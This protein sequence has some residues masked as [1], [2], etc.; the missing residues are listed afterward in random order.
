[1]AVITTRGA[2]WVNSRFAELV[3]GHT[4]RDPLVRKAL[5][6]GVNDLVAG[7]L[8][9]HTKVKTLRALL[10]SLVRFVHQT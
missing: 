6:G 5:I 10:P 7:V 2:T 4:S 3:F 9:G 8:L 1:M